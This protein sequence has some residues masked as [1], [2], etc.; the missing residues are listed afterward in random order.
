MNNEH[1]RDSKEIIKR[2]LERFYK[3]ENDILE[4]AN[5][6]GASE[7][8]LV[9]RLGIHLTDVIKSGKDYGVMKS[10]K[11]YDVIKSDKYCDVMKS[12]KYYDVM[13][14]DKYYVDSDFNLIG[15]LR[16]RFEN[17]VRFPDLIIHDRKERHEMFIEVKK[18]NNRKVNAYYNDIKKI[19]MSLDES[20][21]GYNVGLHLC[22]H[23]NK[24]VCVWHLPS[25][26]EIEYYVFEDGSLKKSE[27][28]ASPMN[29][30]YEEFNILKGLAFI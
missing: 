6:T 3:N 27:K 16:K 8:A 29:R 26:I 5:R 18:E 30:A 21:L 28:F 13:K 25:S 10:N 1:I 14:S 4:R 17:K 9:F 7:R 24:C 11:Y 19:R 12:N 15:D 22:L 20:E 23:Y 2:A